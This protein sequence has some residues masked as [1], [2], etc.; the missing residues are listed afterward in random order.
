MSSFL[1][2]LRL[3]R[4]LNRALQLIGW[5]M[6]SRRVVMGGM[7]VLRSLY[8]YSIGFDP[9]T[10]G[11]FSTV[12]TVV[13]AARSGIVGLLADRYGRKIFVVLGGLFSTLRFA[14]YAS[15]T[16]LWM[17]VLAEG[18][19]AFGEGAG[20]GQ[21][22]M[23]GIIAD[24]SEV[25]DRTIV[26]SIFAFTNAIA[27]TVGSLLAG[28]PSGFQAWFGYGEVT[29]YQL[30]FLM[31]A[32]FSVLST[33][34]VFPLKE[35]PRLGPASR[36]SFF[37]R[38]SWHIIGK[39]SFVRSVGG[40]GFGVTDSLIPLWFKL[41]F[42]VGEEVISLV[43]A[44]SRFLSMFSYFVVIRFADL[45]GA[46]GSLAI[47]RGFSAI[48]MV[49]MAISPSYLV[50]AVLLTAYRVSLM[51]TMP[52]RQSFITSIVDAEERASAVGIS[53]FS[54]MAVRSFAPATGGYVMQTLS[55]ALPFYIGATIVALN[56]ALYYLLFKEPSTS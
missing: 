23:T 24:N 48:V 10:I 7:A 39:F 31:G 42:G 11:L 13:G 22:S 17:L 55:T 51:F 27:S 54:R 26:F 4:G 12:S 41:T 20:A 35:A 30:F 2:G 50:A 44:A 16:N 3:K 45:V 43:Y 32:V 8:L 18:V 56:G 46:I 36:R 52:V 28:L 25:E 21:P 19:G 34:I 6:A 40:F 15:S 47:T 5:S 14:I 1:P 33:V 9:F 49:A 37:P 53:N 29:A 38:K